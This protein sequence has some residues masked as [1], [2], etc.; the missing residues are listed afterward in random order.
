M[1]ETTATDRAAQWEI[2]ALRERLRGL[3]GKRFWRGLD[4]LAEAPEFTEMLKRE[5]PDQA[6]EWT[7]P[8]SRRKFVQLMGASFAFAGLTACSSPK[9]GKILPYVKQPEQLVLGRPL[10]YA[11]ALQFAGVANGVLVES[12]EG[13]PTKIEGNPDHPSNLG[14]SDVFTQAAVLGLFDPDRSKT[15]TL[16]GEIH[17]YSEFVTA[18]RDVLALQKVKAGA[19]L[20]ILTETVGSPTLGAQI[21]AVLADLPKAR[22]HQWEPV[23]NRDAARAAAVAVF[24]RDVVP[25]LKLDAADV[26]VSLDSDFLVWGPNHI[27]YARDFG[28][29]RTPPIGAGHGVAGGE[30]LNRLY[31]FESMPSSTGAVSDHRYR[32]RS[33]DVAAV[34]RALAAEL[35]VAGVSGGKL[36][37]GVPATAI[38]AIAKDLRARGGRAVVVAGD[39]QPSYVHA[40]AAL[41]NDAIGAVG[42]SLVYLDPPEVQS[43]DHAASITQ[44]AGDMKAGKVE[45]LVIVGSNPVVTA[46]AELGFA[47]ALEKVALRVHAGL[48]QDETA[49]RCHWHVPVAHELETW[50]DARAW[51]GTV[52]IVQPLIEPIYGNKTV[53]EVVGAFGPK[54]T[55]PGIE[56][57]KE[58][59][60]AKLGAEFDK[61][62]RRSLHDGFI[63]GTAREP[64]AV[65]V[66]AGWPQALPA[67]AAVDGIE[68]VIRPDSSVYDGRFANNGWLQELPRPMTKLVWDN[69]FHVGPA[70]AEKLGVR[71]E[72]VLEVKVDGRAVR[73][74]VWTV[75]GHADGSITVHLGYGRDRAGAVGNHIGFD[76]YPIRTAAHAWIVAGAEVK[77]TGETYDLVKTHGHHQMEGRGLV[78]YASAD[79]YG[80]NAHFAHEGHEEPEH[81]MYPPYKY[82]RYSWGLAINLSSCIGCSTCT[83]SCV[84]ENNIAVVGKEQVRRGREMHWIRVDRYFEGTKLDDP[85]IW[86]QPV[87]CMHCEN[88]PC[89]QVCP[90]AATVHSSEGL[91]DMAYNRCV[92]TRY[93]SNNCPYKVRRFN[94]LAYSDFST[95][96]LKLARNPDV[97]VRS[98][99][100]MEKSTYCVQ[101]INA[102]RNDAE[103]QGRTIRD[104][105]IVTAC[106]QAC[107]TQAI[108]FGNINDAESKIAKAKADPR[109][110]GILT[111]LNTRPRTS[112]L[113]A[114]RNPNPALGT[115]HG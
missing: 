104:G 89:E 41:I 109:N 48:Y 108:V 97:T 16:R 4:E 100:V 9:T 91:N 3:E 107:P 13:R 86:F 19:G 24:G 76:V 36:P 55:R 60:S 85:A 12:H 22:W 69:A 63:A 18:M 79:E 5:F 29:R 27:R 102:A 30:H 25:L 31:T 65:A 44:L 56:A 17:T 114:V 75:P 66:Q 38:T 51:D 52:S 14:S 2:A 82:D 80:A 58:T 106:Q 11:T 74:P 32:V 43:E 62:W 98:R 81:S 23:A 73:G 101:R 95:E 26:V 1:S 39:A 35:G 92:G 88:A 49:Q 47:D 7:D 103:R 46:P 70:T 71:D 15:V 45:V 53:H 37:E 67:P 72:D 110:Y 111:D 34:A 87:P 99:G 33:S 50:G 42:T 10:Y 20:R 90:V 28:A 112:Y 68:V 115:E 54:P 93:C 8:V 61:V 21:Q 78:R 40:L 96:S 6:D 59:W 64:V 94:F 57:I 77:K 84:A 105:E 83:M 113:A